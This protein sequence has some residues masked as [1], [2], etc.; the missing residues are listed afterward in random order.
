VNHVPLPK[1]AAAQAA[2]V[3]DGAVRA[4]PLAGIPHLL[5]DLGR[6]PTAVFAAAGFDT[7]L[8][9]H[10]ENAVS[11]NAIGRLLDTC[12]DATDCRHFGLLLGR[13][14]GIECLGLVGMLAQHAPTVGRA[15]RNIVMNLHLHDR[16]AVPTLSVADDEAMLSYTICQPGVMGRAQI[17]DITAVV[18]FNILR[19]LCGPSFRPKSVLLPHAK[20]DDP[21]PFR[22]VFGVTPSYDADRM[23]LIF[24]TCFTPGADRWSRPR[25]CCRCT[26]APSTVVSSVRHQLSPTPR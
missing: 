10:P 12:A 6:D 15:L 17:Y 19:A 26:P 25:M 4:G 8:L 2:A 16:G 9:D 23:A 20:P 3:T 5:R 7:R 18:G 13:R 24:A 11:F 22:D 1:N 14:D 21:A